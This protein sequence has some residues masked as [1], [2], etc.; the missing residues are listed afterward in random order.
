MRAFD[1]RPLGRSGIMT[2]VMGFGT[3]PLGD[4]YDIL[5]EDQAHATVRAAYDAGIR[6]FDTAPLYGHGLAEHRL[7]S[8]LRQKPRDHYLISSK[9][10][11]VYRPRGPGEAWDGAGYKGGLP[12]VPTFDYSYDGAMRSVEQSLLRLGTD[13]L[14]I[15]L[16]HDVDVWTHGRESIDQR[17][18]E[19]MEG[20]Y[21]ALDSLRSQKVVGA[22]G[23]GIN[24]SD[25]CHRFARAGDFDCFMLA[26]RYTLLEQGA[27]DA[28]FPECERRNIGILLGGVFNSGILAGGKAYNY[29]EAPLHITALVR[30]IEEVCTAYGVSL[31]AAALHFAAAHPVVSSLVLGAVKPD[32]IRRN[33]VAFDAVIPPALWSDLKS[34]GLLRRDAPVP[35]KA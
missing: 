34:E 6:L 2:T 1:K 32:E 28:I 16:I 5:D 31:A 20:A 29:K 19:A 18:G 21:R 15:L 11:R 30:R 12:F 22:I 35:P 13:R 26:G 14:D 7:G 10:G 27:M 3:A 25:M 33:T 24:E 4:L 17:F 8:I 23:V 9:V